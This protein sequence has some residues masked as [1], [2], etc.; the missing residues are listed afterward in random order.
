ME[1]S[2]K[3]AQPVATHGS[4]FGAHGKERVDRST[5]TQFGNGHQMVTA[6]TLRTFPS[7]V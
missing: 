5:P 2:A 3:Q 4:G 6:C 7:A 1:L